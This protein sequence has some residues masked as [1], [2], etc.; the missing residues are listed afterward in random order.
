MRAIPELIMGSYIVGFDTISYY[1]PVTWKW[2]RCGVSFWEF[3]G[4]APMLYLL[5][6]GLTLAGVPLVVTLKVLPP[7]LHGL[8]GFAIFQYATRGLAWPV[9]KAFFASLLA[10]LYFVGLRISWDMLRSELGL[11]FLFILL[12]ML[13]RCLSDFNWKWLSILTLFAVLLVLTH[14]LVSIVMFVI[15]FAMALERLIKRDYSFVKRIFFACLPAISLFLLTVYADFVVLPAYVDGVVASGR[16]EWLNLMG[17]SST[18]NGIAYTVGFLFFCYFPILPFAALGIQ[19]F[20]GLEF[21]VWAFWCLIGA[22]LPFLFTLAP[23]SYR[24]FLLLAFPLAFFAVEGFEKLNSSLF[25]AVLAGFMVL[26]SF[27]F[28]F[29][30]AEAAFPYF[31][32]FPSYVPSSMLQNSVPLSDCEDVIKALSWMENNV[33][34]DGVLLVHDAFYGWALLYADGVEIVRYGYALPENAALAFSQDSYRRV[35][36]IWWVSGEGWHGWA[37]LPSTFKEAYRS[38]RIAVYEFKVEA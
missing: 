30:P 14:Q 15:I 10:T 1:V 26:L 31:S 7:L 36:L 6:S 3:F 35:Y 38:G 8:L 34:R 11:L 9:R 27:S 17:Y 23:L 13:R 24:W 20:R 12:I 2:T 16:S 37:S 32:L 22:S 29:L 18:A 28:I 25:K 33:E 21:K 4:T 19:K 5:L